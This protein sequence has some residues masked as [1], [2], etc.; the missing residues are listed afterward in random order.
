M[1]TTNYSFSRQVGSDF[2]KTVQKV[3]EALSDEGFG[4]LT[5]I[6]IKAKMKEKLQKDMED[7]IILGACN[8]PSAYKVLQEETEIGLLLPCNV[9]VYVKDDDTHVAAIRP[10]Q[11]MN[12]IDNPAL[13][14][15]A[16]EIEEKLKTALQSV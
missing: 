12:M 8:P 2:D 6:D 5:K 1:E 3:I 9:I 16:R 11:A 4:I 13:E 7:Y 10:T 14:E 15:T